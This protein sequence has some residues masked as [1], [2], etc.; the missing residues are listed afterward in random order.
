MG[1]ISEA[2]LNT[3]KRVLRALTSDRKSMKELTINVTSTDDQEI[4][5]A[6]VAE[7]PEPSESRI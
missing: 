5:L 7:A 4:S 1:S 3:L 2:I 6:F